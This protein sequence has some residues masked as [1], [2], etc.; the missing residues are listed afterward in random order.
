MGSII[1]PLEAEA[2][3]VSLRVPLAAAA[4]RTLEAAAAASAGLGSPLNCPLM[5]AAMPEGPG[6]GGA[7]EGADDAEA[8]AADAAAALFFAMICDISRL[9]CSRS[10]TALAADVKLATS[11]SVR[12]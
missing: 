1:V 6:V 7:V 8:L 2:T 5:V 11:Q 4:A 9:K 3:G 12:G 10:D